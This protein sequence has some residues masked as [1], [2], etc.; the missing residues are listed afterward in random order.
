M[1]ITDEHESQKLKAENA[2]RK[3]PLDM[4]VIDAGFMQ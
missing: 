2:K 1:L 4:D 3:I